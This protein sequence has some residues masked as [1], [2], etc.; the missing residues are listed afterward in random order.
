MRGF[1]YSETCDC[2]KGAGK[3][4]NPLKE[5]YFTCPVCGGDGKVI[6]EIKKEGS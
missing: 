3:I 1:T 2:C 5:F 6:K 4:K